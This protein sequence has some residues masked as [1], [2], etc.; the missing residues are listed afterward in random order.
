MIDKNYLEDNVKDDKG[1]IN[2]LNS[3]KNENESYFMKTNP[4]VNEEYVNELMKEL[5]LG[6]DYTVS[7]GSNDS[8]GTGTVTI[9]GKGEYTGKKE[10][11]FGIAAGAFNKEK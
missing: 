8:A 9:T 10:V 4:K 11:T 6:D 3:Y 7:Y 5:T 1:N 2:L